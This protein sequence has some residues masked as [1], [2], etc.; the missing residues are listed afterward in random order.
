[1]EVLH[2]PI[3]WVQSKHKTQTTIQFFG[4]LFILTYQNVF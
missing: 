1:M 2:E 3:F 4:F